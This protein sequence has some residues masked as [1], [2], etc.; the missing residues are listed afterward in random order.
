MVEAA[1]PVTLTIKQVPDALAQS[2]RERAERHRRSL[3]RELLL[4]LEEAQGLAGAEQPASRLDLQEPPARAYRK[5]DGG[6]G[7]QSTKR[8]ASSA[9]PVEQARDGKLS[10]KELWQRARKLGEASP[11][12]SAALIR[13]DRDANHGH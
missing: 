2:L 6:V 1:M 10:L 11:A 9:T 12:E 3:Q 7:R 13:R 5:S 4:I 8:M